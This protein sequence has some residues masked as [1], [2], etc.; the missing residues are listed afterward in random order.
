MSSNPV[1]KLVAFCGRIVLS[2][3]FHLGHYSLL[4]IRALVLAILPPWRIRSI[5]RQME[6]V[7]VN[8]LFV[9]ILTGLF[10]GAVFTLQ[11]IYG[12]RRFSAESMVG[13]TV[14]TAMTRELGP[15]LTAL[16]VTGRV[17]SAMA[18]ELSAMKVTEQIDALNVM[19]ADPVKYLITPRILAAIVMLPL[20]TAVADAVG[21]IGG[22]LVAIGKGLDPG[23]FAS[24]IQ[25]IV[26]I[27]DVYN[28]LIKAAVFGFILASVGCYM[29]FYTKGGAEGVGHSTTHAVV[30]AYVAILVGDFVMTA[31]MF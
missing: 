15:V 25:D 8:S 5:F 7:G 22:Y 24:R 1:T 2:S 9:V 28:G 21:V 30:C 3:V 18:A 4:S 11:V 26:V 19:G 27:G 29:G 6:L 13:P 17:G 10:T 12:F 16:M 14:A 31:M 23:Q 20:L